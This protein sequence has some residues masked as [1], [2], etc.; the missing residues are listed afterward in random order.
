MSAPFVAGTVAL[1][2]EANPDLTPEQA[3][4]IIMESADQEEFMGELPNNTYGAGTINSL[5]AVKEAVALAGIESPVADADSYGARAWV[6]GATVYVALHGAEGK[7]VAEVYN[8]AGSLIATYPVENG[9][10]AIDASA[11]G[12]GIFIVTING[13]GIK[14]AL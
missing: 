5:A 13:D 7:N 9:L 8:V 10:S 6:E 3:R 2:L 11:W 12:H 14:V 1:M 4:D